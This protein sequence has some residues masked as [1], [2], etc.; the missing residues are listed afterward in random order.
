MIGLYTN[1]EFET[2]KH[3]DLL[4]CKCYQCDTEYL[5]TKHIIKMALADKNPNS[6]KNCY[7]SKKCISDALRKKIEFACNNCGK[8]IT[9]IPHQA[10]A[11]KNHFCSHSCN[12]SFQNKNKTCGTRRSKLEIYL[13]E[14]LTKY[15]PELTILYNCKD[16]INSELDIY[17]PSLK[18]AFELNGIFHYEPI[19]GINKLSTIQN[20][21]SRKFQACLEH[22]ISL[23]IINTSKVTYNKPK[24]FK[25]YLDIII[26]I[27]NDNLFTSS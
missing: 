10:T 3:K 20:N 11:Y 17:I 1:E 9:R 23:C 8:S 5:T 19:F 7:C 12:A 22:N 4:K 6:K 2:A 25:K 14:Q 24:V 26:G 21:D 18:L 16:V 13:E 27:V 15:Y